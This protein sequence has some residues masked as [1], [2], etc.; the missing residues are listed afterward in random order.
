MTDLNQLIIKFDYEKNFKDDD[1]YVSKSNKNT[2][3]ILSNWPKWEK[4]F[5]NIT[6]DKYSGK[7]HLINI[8]IKK[9]KGI[10]L[11][12]V[13]LSDEDLTKIKIYENIILE[14]LSEKVDEKLIYTLLNIIDIDNKYIIITSEKPIVQINFSLSDLKS[15]TK[16][17]IIQKI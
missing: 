16:N 7:T 4:K 12:A 6:G 14:N 5:L 9:F 13:S 10:K 17:F 3:D 11:D 2:F 15:R 1:F 8:F